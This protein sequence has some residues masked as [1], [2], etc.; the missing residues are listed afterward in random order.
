MILK[1]YRPTALTNSVCELLERMINARLVRVFEI[2]HPIAPFQRGFRKGRTTLD[3]L[4]HLE[5]GVMNA[6]IKRKYFYLSFYWYWKGIWLYLALRILKDMYDMEFRGNLPI[7]IS[8]FL[9]SR[10]FNVR[11]GNFLSETFIQNA[12]VQQGSLLTIS[13]FS[14]KVKSIL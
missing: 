5:S 4:L 14:I 9:I 13:L 10:I 1:N 7:F 2:A 8:D 12:G 11:I 6:Y 3:N